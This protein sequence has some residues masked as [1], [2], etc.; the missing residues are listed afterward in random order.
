MMTH[1]ASG[2]ARHRRLSLPSLVLLTALIAITLSP[3]A[4]VA[5]T[6]PEPIQVTGTPVLLRGGDGN[7]TDPHI[8]GTLVAYTA[9]E[10][11]SREVRYHD[12]ATGSDT[13]IPQGSHLDSLPDV[14]GTTIVFRRVH[15]DGSTSTRPIMAFDTANPGAGAVEL[16]PVEGAR[17]DLSS[18]GGRTVAWMELVGFSSSHTD[19]VAYDLDSGQ[20]TRL[21]T[22]GADVRNQDPAVSLD[23]AVVTWSKCVLD[24]SICDVYAVSKNADGTWN[25]AIQISDDPGEENYPD[26]NGQV[27]AY[28]SNAGGE[29]GDD[30]S[31]RWVNVDGTDERQLIMPGVQFNPNMSGNLISFESQAVGATNPDL[32]V[33]DLASDLLYQVTNTPDVNESLNDIAFGADGTV[34]VV[35]AQA[36]GL[37]SGNNDVYVMSFELAGTALYEIC[38]LFDQSRAYRLK[39]TVPIRIQ[40]CDAQAQN[41]S[42]ES[43][44]VTATELVK[45]DGTAASTV[46]DDAGNANP[47]D[48]FRYDPTLGGT[49]GY[50]YN[51]STKGLSAGT[52]ELRFTVTGDTTTY[53]VRFD[54]R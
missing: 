24:S 36:D 28:A 4:A 11:T 37:S 17:R 23:G 38:P 29:D 13:A 20:A 33:Y 46:V 16:D 10:G 35:W 3:L 44:V 25:S 34:R 31:I 26:T 51:L 27:I 14:S 42:S 54:L 53:S 1:F 50:I 39:S 40:L 12:L 21:T 15:T 8:S 41:L 5:Q 49:G 22:D 6:A 45:M 43:V 47:D 19:I 30:F 7:Q 9:V 48:A 32:F 2:T 18:I 52:W